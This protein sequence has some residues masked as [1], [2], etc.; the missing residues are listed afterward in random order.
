MHEDIPDRI[1]LER[2]LEIFDDAQQ[3]EIVM[4]A[5]YPK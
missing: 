3:F 4:A 1:L 5:I 2:A